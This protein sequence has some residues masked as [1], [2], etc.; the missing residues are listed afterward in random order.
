MSNII[1]KE[2]LLQVAPYVLTG[3]AT[4]NPLT[5]VLAESL[6]KLSLNTLL[7]I[8]YSRIDQLPEDMLDLLAKD[9]KVEWYNYNQSVSV[10]RAVIKD[11]FYV[12][13]HLGTVG[14]VKRAISDVW[15]AFSLEEWFDYGGDPYHFRVAVADNDF[16][17]SKREEARK[18][19]NATKNVRSTLDDIYAQAFINIAVDTQSGG[20]VVDETPPELYEAQVDVTRCDESYAAEEAI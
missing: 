9:F 10:K 3:D 4:M 11:S 17:I 5:E 2:M 16:T 8:I 12:H 13:R 20:Y 1:T 7:P 19:I 14:A 6:S 18:L 15:D